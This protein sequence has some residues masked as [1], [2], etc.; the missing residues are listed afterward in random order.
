MVY[1]PGAA[2]NDDAPEA[3]PA[4]Y[5]PGAAED[6]GEEEEVPLVDAVDVAPL[7]PAVDEEETK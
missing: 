5:N 2:E 4:G 7:P 6:P 1:N 3:D